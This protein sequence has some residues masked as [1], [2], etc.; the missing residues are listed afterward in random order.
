MLGRS[1][2][3]FILKLT[4]GYDVATDQHEDPLV[5]IVEKAMQGFAV[6]SEPGSFIVDYFPLLKYLPWW[7]P[8]GAF[9]WIARSMRADLDRLYDVP[10]EFVTNQMVAVY[11]LSF[12]AHI[13]AFRSIFTGCRYRPPIVHIILPE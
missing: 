9:K 10:F 8:G 12:K 11:L 2:G 13:D 7:M 3:A 1:T 4:Y 6:A 5:Q